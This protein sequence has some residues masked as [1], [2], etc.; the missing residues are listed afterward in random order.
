MT[1]EIETA[2][3]AVGSNGRD[4][5]DAT[6][7]RASETSESNSRN[8][9]RGRVRGGCIG[10]GGK[11]GHGG[12]GVRFNRPSYTSSIRTFKIEVEGFGAILG[13]T[14]EQIEAKD[15]YNKS[16]EKLKH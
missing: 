9:E 13:T 11:Q 10:R 4:V 14:S 3:P 2:S 12:R 1:Q 16:S 5:S 15:Q 7:T 8:R 6:I